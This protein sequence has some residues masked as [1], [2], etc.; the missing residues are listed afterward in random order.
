MKVDGIIQKGDVAKY[1]II[2]KH[3]N[4][5]MQRDDFFVI[6]HYGM[7]GETMRIDKEQMFHDEDG[8]WFLTLPSADLPLGQ[9]KAE[10]HY[11]VKD[12]DM[13]DHVRE[14]AEW[15]WIGFV[16][17]SPCP[18]FAYK[19]K[20]NMY[21]CENSNNHVKFVRVWR[22]DANSMYM[23]L[24]TS[25]GEP[26]KDSTELQLQVQKH[27]LGDMDDMPSDYRLQFTGPEIDER[28]AQVG[29][30]KDAIEKETTRAKEAEQQLQE[31]ING[32]NEL[33]PG[34]ATPDNQ[35]ADKDFVNSSIATNSAHFKGTYSSAEELQEVDATNN[36]YAIVEQTDEDGNSSYHRY[37]YVDGTGWSFE[38]S[39]NN[40]PFTSEQWKA[41]NS[42]ITEGDVEKLRALLTREQLDAILNGKQDAIADLEDIRK[43]AKAG[44]TA[45]QPSELKESEKNLKE[46]FNKL[47]ERVSGLEGIGGGTYEPTIDES[48]EVNNT[49]GSIESGT[50]LS[51]LKGK[52]FSEL[53]DMMLVK[54]TWTD[55]KYSHSVGLSLKESIVLVGSAVSAPVVT[56][57]WNSNVTPVDNNNIQTN[58]IVSPTIGDDN[59][60]KTA[61]DYRYTLGYSYGEGYYDINSNLGHEKRITVPAVTNGSITRVL[62]ATYN[63]Y[64][65]GA[66]QSPLVPINTAYTVT[67]SLT[68]QPVIKIPGKNSEINVQADLGFG[69]MDVEW[70]K[71]IENDPVAGID[72]VVYTKP[73]SY[74]ASVPHRITFTIRL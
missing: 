49:I 27:D 6:F 14:E 4:F 20:H 47:E 67:K 15:D 16:T 23:T 64:V 41:I 54:E 32:I 44:A 68:G 61:G 53:T 2:I 1:Q 56:A 71:T 28:L 18:Q 46:Q 59:I 24:R 55:P 42:A 43:G 26:T 25:E 69:Y 9:V 33:I 40:T 63:W 37:K 50:P 39:I 58:L 12:S 29:E 70:V 8:N 11:M 74:S 3:A 66:A 36:D 38:F 5:N 17:E 52:T 31:S 65:D 62:Q 45:V 21:L 34:Q 19:C 30:N 73:D 35:L 51:E 60:V 13:S 10:T 22:G 7:T 48:T 72:Y 57:T